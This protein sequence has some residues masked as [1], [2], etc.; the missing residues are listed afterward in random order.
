MRNEIYPACRK[1]P[2]AL[3]ERTDEVH[4]DESLQ[5]TTPLRRRRFRGPLS[6]R[7]ASLEQDR[8]IRLGQAEEGEEQ[9]GSAHDAAQPRRPPPAQ[10]AGGDEAAEDGREQGAAQ[11]HADAGRHR[12]G[13]LLR[14]PDVDE[15]AAEQGDGGH[16]RHAAEKSPGQDRPQGRAHGDGDAEDGEERQAREQGP[17]AAEPLGQGAPHR[18][19]D[20]VALGHHEVQLRALSVGGSRRDCWLTATKRLTPRV[21]VSVLALNSRLMA[22]APL[23]NMLLEM[24]A[25]KFP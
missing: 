21:T 2:R 5:A 20:G 22:S 6:L 8:R 9:A 13:P 17:A 12:D 3:T 11:H 15:A 24:D 18:R 14:V 23:L 25:T 10:V 4:P 1:W 7:C 16:A 19:A